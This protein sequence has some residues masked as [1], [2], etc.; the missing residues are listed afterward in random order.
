MDEA[1]PPNILAFTRGARTEPSTTES[2][3]EGRFTQAGA[4]ARNALFGTALQR[5]SL[6]G[7]LRIDELI[8]ESSV[9]VWRLWI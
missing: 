1:N 4:V 5:L 7:A 6:A 8:G 3:H 2:R 9:E